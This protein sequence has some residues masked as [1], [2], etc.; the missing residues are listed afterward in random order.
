MILL[1]VA[2]STP[3]INRIND[4][5]HNW[6]YFHGTLFSINNECVCLKYNL[7]AT[8]D[9]Q[10]LEYAKIEHKNSS[11]AQKRKAVVINIYSG[12]SKRGPGGQKKYIDPNKNDG[13]ENVKGL[14]A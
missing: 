7:F 13:A 1:L 8:E 6:K 10:T 2:L 14:N 9:Y 4:I 11:T 5:L 3:S 12:M